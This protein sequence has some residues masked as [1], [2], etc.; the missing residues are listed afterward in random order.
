[1][2]SSTSNSQDYQ[3]MASGSQDHDHVDMTITV[4]S[5]ATATTS[6]TSTGLARTPVDLTVVPTS[7][8][9][10]ARNWG[11]SDFLAGRRFTNVKKAV[12]AIPVRAPDGNPNPAYANSMRLLVDTATKKSALTASE[13]K[14]L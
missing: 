10:A 5:A 3:S 7:V 13:E 12:N 8:Q 9:N 6:G 14:K 4:A 11:S 2:L 1:M